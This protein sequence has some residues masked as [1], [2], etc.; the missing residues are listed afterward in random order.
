MDVNVTSEKKS[1]LQRACDTMCRDI[2]QCWR[3]QRL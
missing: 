1:M 3:D 2:L